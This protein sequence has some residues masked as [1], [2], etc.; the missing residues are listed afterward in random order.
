[1]ANFVQINRSYQA[2]SR[3]EDIAK[4]I[5]AGNDGYLNVGDSVSCTLKNGTEVVFDVLALN[6]YEPDS[7]AFGIR[8]IHWRKPWNDR[9]TNAGGWH[10]TKIRQNLNSGEIFNLFPD[11]LVEMITP[12]KIVQ[13]IGGRTYES[14]DKFWLLSYT[15]VFGT[16][17]G[18]D[19][20]GDVGDVQFDF[21][22]TKKNRVKFLNG[23]PYYHALRS[24]LVGYS[25]NFWYVHANGYCS[26]SYGASNSYGVCPCFIIS[27]KKV[28]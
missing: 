8:D 20:T 4:Q 21:F 7:V 24:P 1:M 6:P 22:K 25:T 16:D 17:R 15:E 18:T 26:S 14:L 12:R 23:E 11:D 27:K 10:D 5:A 9:N 3:W 19:Q 13:R 28:S 2:R